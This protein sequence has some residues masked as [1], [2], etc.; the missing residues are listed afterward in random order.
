[1]AINDGWFYDWFKNGWFPSVWFA[2]GDESGIPDDELRPEYH[3]GGL[4]RISERVPQAET[5]DDL[6]AKVIDKWETIERLANVS[7]VAESA[8]VSGELADDPVAVESF[9]IEMPAVGSGAVSTTPIPRVSIAVDV[10]DNKRRRS[11]D[12]LLLLALAIAEC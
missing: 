6:I 11:D 1:M 12:D 9:D 5:E 8:E 7:R 2:P 4:K 10:A 3:G